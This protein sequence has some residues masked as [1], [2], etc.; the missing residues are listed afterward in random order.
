LWR[1][2]RAGDQRW[3]TTLPLDEEFRR[4]MDYFDALGI[5]RVRTL[6]DVGANEGQFLFPA[7][8]YL[9]PQHSVAV[10]MLPDAAARL[11]SRAPASVAIYQCA[12]GA[13]SGQ[14]S[15]RRSAYCQAS[16]LLPIRP[17]A[18]DLYGLDL[19]Q[20]DPEPVPMLTLDDICEDAGI[21]SVDLLKLDVQG[22]EL[23]VL[24]GAGRILER[25]RDIIVEVEFVPIYDGGPLFPAVWQDLCGRGFRLSQLFGQWRSPEGILL[26]ADAYFKSQRFHRTAV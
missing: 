2:Y 22:Y 7:L 20:T 1:L 8:K 5:S 4:G 24:R 18:S 23:E 10:E 11:R 21:E 15:C 19:H 25:T 13:V 12:A 14:G 9:A 6:V 26:H 16:S 3:R 17:E